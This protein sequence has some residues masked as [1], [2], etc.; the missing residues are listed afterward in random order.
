MN[1]YLILAIASGL[2]INAMTLNVNAQDVAPPTLPASAC[3]H[4]PPISI[5][6]NKLLHF[7]SPIRIPNAY[8]V[9][10]KCEKALAV[11]TTNTASHRSQV[12]LGT[13]PTNQATASRWRPHM[14][15]ASEAVLAVFGVVLADF[16]GSA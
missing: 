9:Q 11:D 6:E 8:L 7:D 2:L 16:E 12:L 4:E 14:L 13:L 15:L 10:F 3:V 1:N 5:P